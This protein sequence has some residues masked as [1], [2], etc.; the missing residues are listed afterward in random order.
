MYKKH[1]EIQLGYE[2]MILGLNLSHLNIQYTFT[3]VMNKTAM[4]SDVTLSGN[5]FSNIIILLK[6]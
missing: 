2:N 4:T 3:C 6:S 1:L 5:V